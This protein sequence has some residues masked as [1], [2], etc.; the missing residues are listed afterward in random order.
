[1]QKYLILI[2]AVLFLTNISAQEEAD[3][4]RSRDSEHLKDLHWVIDSTYGIFKT[5]KFSNMKV[6]YPTYKTFKTFIDT[7]AAGDQGEITKYAMYNRW[8]NG[9]RLQY[10]KLIRKAWKAGID[11]KK[12]TLDSIHIDTG[13]QGG[14]EYAYVQWIIKY[15]NKKKYLIKGLYLKMD[16][17]WFMMDELKFMGVI[18]EKKKKKKTKKK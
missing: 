18:V 1:M 5:M 2:F 13:G 8:W 16:G 3:S 7:S 4:S 14:N 6:I 17:K 11:W 10:T 9:L 15:N 12:T